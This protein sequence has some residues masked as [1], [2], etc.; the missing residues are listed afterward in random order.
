MTL[1]PSKKTKK[2]AGIS[3]SQLGIQNTGLMWQKEMQEQLQ[4]HW[5][6]VPSRIIFYSNPRIKQGRLSESKEDTSGS[7]SG[8]RVKHVPSGLRWNLQKEDS[9]WGTQCSYTML[10]T[11]EFLIYHVSC[12]WLD[13][14]KPVLVD[15]FQFLW[16]IILAMFLAPFSTFPF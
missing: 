1:C 5:M 8:L 13:L 6:G 3:F 2:R 9:A 7:S 10:E 14:V 12:L 15:N 16:W 4:Y 11:E